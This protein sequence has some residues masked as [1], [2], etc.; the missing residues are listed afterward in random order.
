MAVSPTPLS[1]PIP[2][3]HSTLLAAVSLLPP[4]PD[5][6]H[7]T[8]IK[9]WLQ[10]L[11]LDHLYHL[12][13]A[14]AY[15]SLERVVHLQP[16]ELQLE[17]IVRVLWEEGCVCMCCGGRGVCMCCGGRVCVCMGCGGEGVC[18]CMGCGGRGC[19]CACVVGGRCVCVCMCCV[20][21]VHTHTSPHS[22][23]VPFLPSQQ[24]GQHPPLLL[25]HQKR[26]TYA[27]A[28]L[29]MAHPEWTGQL[30]PVARRLSLSVGG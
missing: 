14:N 9:S 21:H 22:A 15:G 3:P 13:V 28:Q 8:D 19:V 23:H 20:C 17:G 5:S 11:K 24:K 29:S 12:L 2:S 6:S 26:L 7:V 1:R 27:I 18:V 10:V 30:S 16:W 25:G 4:P